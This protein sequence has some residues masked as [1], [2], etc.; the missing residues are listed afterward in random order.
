MNECTLPSFQSNGN[1]SNKTKQEHST[2]ILLRLL[3]YACSAVPIHSYNTIW[4][5]MIATA[6]HSLMCSTARLEANIGLHMYSEKVV[7]EVVRNRLIIGCFFKAGE[8]IS[9]MSERIGGQQSLD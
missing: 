5:L 2:R 3:R 7:S 6:A 4:S 9:W 8:L 1:N